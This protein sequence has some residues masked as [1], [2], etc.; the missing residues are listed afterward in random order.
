MP[1]GVFPD[2]EWKVFQT[3]LG[4]DDRLILYTDG[5]IEARRNGDFFGDERLEDIIRDAQLPVEELPNR[6]LDEVLAFSDGALKDDVAVLALSL[7]GDGPTRL[8]AR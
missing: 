5:V 2:A 8:S 1:L 3:E 4:V 7:T 6:V